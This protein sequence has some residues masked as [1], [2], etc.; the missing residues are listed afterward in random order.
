MK[1]IVLKADEALRIHLA[2]SD[3]LVLAN[4]SELLESNSGN[5]NNNRSSMSDMDEACEEL[6]I[7]DLDAAEVNDDA[8]DV[9]LQIEETKVGD[10]EGLEVPEKDIVLDN[11]CVSLPAIHITIVKD[12]LYYLLAI[13]NFNME[14]YFVATGAAS[15]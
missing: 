2:E 6:L 5:E 3:Y 11:Y 9:V 4:L 14:N 7:S 8:L 15:K 1:K 13:T 12:R 10:S